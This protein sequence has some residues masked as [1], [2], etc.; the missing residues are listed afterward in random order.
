MPLQTFGENVNN[1][2]QTAGETPTWR[3]LWW[4]VALPPPR[5]A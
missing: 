4:L 1:I 2:M 5:L 3:A